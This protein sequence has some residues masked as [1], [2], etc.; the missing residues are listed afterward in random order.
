MVVKWGIKMK[1]WEK[2]GN[3][4]EVGEVDVLFRDTND[5]GKQVKVSNNWYIWRMNEPFIDVGKLEGDNQKAE[6]GIV[7]AP[8]DIID[9]MRTGKYDFVYPDF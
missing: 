1:L 2:V 3:V 9:R 7:V 5:Y 8:P 6:I 4:P